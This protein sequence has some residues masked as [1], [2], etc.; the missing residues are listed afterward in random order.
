MPSR[1]TLTRPAL[2][3][4]TTGAT[5]MA[6]YLWIS[7]DEGHKP[8]ASSAAAGSPHCSTRYYHQRSRYGLK[9]RKPRR[10]STWPGFE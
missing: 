9:Q 2:D 6:P 8:F 3:L 4:T 10:T 7:A 1:K 5:R